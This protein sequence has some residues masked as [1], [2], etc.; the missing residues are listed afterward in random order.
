MTGEQSKFIKQLVER[1]SAAMWRYAYRQIGDQQ[2]AQDMVQETFLTACCKA[3]VVCRHENPSG[4]LFITLHHLIL[5]E[6]TK[7]SREVS[8][9]NMEFISTETEEIDLPL[10]LYLPNTLSE[11]DREILLWRLRDEYTFE[12]IA[13]RRGISEVACRQQLSRAMRRCREELE[14]SF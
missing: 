4:W 2:T 3:E 13:R 1:N 12:E 14:K 6:T 10:E 9:E 5:R 8:C 7:R 11:Q